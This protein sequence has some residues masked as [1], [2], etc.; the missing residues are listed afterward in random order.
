[1]RE[2]GCAGLAQNLAIS[3]IAVY[4]TVKIPIMA[5]GAEV[6]VA[7]RNTDVITG[8]DA[9][10]RVFVTAGAGFAARELSARVFVQNAGEVKMFN[11]KTTLRGSTTEADLATSFNVKVPKGALT[12][13]SRYAVEIVE[14]GAA[15]GGTA[16]M[17]RFPASDGAALGARKTG[18]LKIRILPLQVNSLLPDT[19]E[20]GL[21]P[22]KDRF[23]ALYPI[24]D[25][26]FTV[27]SPVTIQSATDWS[28]N[29]ERVSQQRRTDAPAADVYYYGLIK[30]ASTLREFC[31]GGCTT[32]I[33]YV[34]QG[35]GANQ[36][37]QRAA[38]GIGF[39]DGASADTMTHEVGH[40]SGRHHAPCGSGI[41]GVDPNFPY[42]GG[43]I[44][45]WGYDAA[46]GKLISPERTTDLMGYCN[47]KWLSDYTYD[48]L[49]NRVAT[50]NGNQNLYVPPELVQAWDVII[51]EGGAARWGLPI[52]QPAAPGGEG[53]P[54]EILDAFGR[55]IAIETVYRTEISDIDAF[56][57][58]VPKRRHGWHGIH[59]AG[60]PPLAY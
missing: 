33:G 57:F 45:V 40:N 32:G 59:V 13:D 35:S 23:M 46:S 34:P 56:S 51:V 50:V 49:L 7:M 5:N 2:D 26:E 14:C 47:T 11:A 38:L 3:Q 39:A 60:A 24:D 4:Q 53:E 19:S 29:L 1:M 31:G 52:D 42:M 27:A 17:P 18:V 21:K 55:V 48:G 22:Y 25:V 58:E 9:L 16:M 37:G 12:P 8:K 10:F 30:P 54:A 6:P 28:R 44:G 43:G 15:P 41:E 20:A 36:A